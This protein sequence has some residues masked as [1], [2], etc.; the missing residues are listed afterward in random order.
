MGKDADNQKG[1]D[2][3]NMSLEE[4]SMLIYILSHRKQFFSPIAE[5][6]K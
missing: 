2:L 5:E 6:A 4:M 3:D 1:L